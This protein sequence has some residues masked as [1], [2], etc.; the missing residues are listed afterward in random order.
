MKNK[1]NVGFTIIQWTGQ[2]SP[3]YA[4]FFFLLHMRNLFTIM[5]AVSHILYISL[6]FLCSLVQTNQLSRI[7]GETQANDPI[8]TLSHH[9]SHL[10]RK[11]KYIS[12]V[13]IFSPRNPLITCRFAEEGR[14]IYDVTPAM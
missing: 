8:H 9:T 7:E 12:A 3:I 5:L 11:H 13:A 2:T 14:T 10:S 4:P 6:S 1:V